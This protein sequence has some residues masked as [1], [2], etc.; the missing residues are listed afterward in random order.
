M[1]SCRSRHGDRAGLRWPDLAP[2]ETASACNGCG[3]CRSLEPTVADVPDFRALAPE[4]AT[5]RSQ[6]NLIRAAR[7]RRDRSQA[8]GQRGV[9]G[10]TPTSAFTATSAPTECP[11]GGRRLEPDARGQ[12]GLRRE[13]R[14]A[15]G[16]LDLLADRALG[17][18][19]EPAADLD[20]L[21]AD[22]ADRRAGCS[23]DL[24]GVSRHRLLPRAQRTPFTRRAARL[25]LTKPRPH[26]RARASS[27]L[28]TSSPTTSTRSWPRRS[29]PSSIRPKSMS[30]S[31]R[32]SAARVWPHWSSATSITRATWR[33]PTCASWPT[34]SATATRSSAP[35]RPPL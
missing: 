19:G 18:A 2:V 25:G 4:A 16:R 24:L 31:R 30:S 3:T 22:R 35:S 13:S 15:P 23:S 20:Q 26:R 29:W 27:T 9:Q 33:W 32:A 5:P 11:S 14:P 6:A 1:P 21:P 10:T 8:L 7:R 12:G 28:S 34:R 17:A